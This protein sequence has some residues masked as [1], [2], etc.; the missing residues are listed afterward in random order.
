VP[1]LQRRSWPKPVRQRAIR[2]RCSASW[3]FLIPNFEGAVNPLERSGPTVILLLLQK[4]SGL[5]A[6][7]TP[8]YPQSR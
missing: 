5:R 2:L 6:S 7:K 3:H 4:L 1:C 8:G